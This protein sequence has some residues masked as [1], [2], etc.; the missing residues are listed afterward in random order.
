MTMGPSKA[1]ALSLALLQ[2]V[3]GA[4]CVLRGPSGVRREV[5]QQTGVELDRELGLTLGRMTLAV[6]RAVVKTEDEDELPLREISKV[7]VGVYRV[8]GA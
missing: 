8:V 5:V 6:A 4:A 7:Q 1:L 2:L 3:V